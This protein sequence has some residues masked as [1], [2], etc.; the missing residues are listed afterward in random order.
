M[1]VVLTLLSSTSTGY[2]FPDA[3]GDGVEDRKDQCIND[4]ENINGYLDWDGCPE[5]AGFQSDGLIDS[6][7]DSIPDAIDNCPTDPENYNKFQDE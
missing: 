6:D 1:T 3:D 4:P 5:A 2:Q 7:Y